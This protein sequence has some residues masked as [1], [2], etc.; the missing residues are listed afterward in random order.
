MN[1]RLTGLFLVA[2]LISLSLSALPYSNS[3]SSLNEDSYMADGLTM[4]I[5]NQ[6][7]KKFE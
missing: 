4:G 3:A 6:F 5:I 7:P 2:L 1:R